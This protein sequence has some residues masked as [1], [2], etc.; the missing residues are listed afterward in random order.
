MGGRQ[1]EMAGKPEDKKI[2]QIQLKKKKNS[3][4]LRDTDLVPM[5]D[6]LRLTYSY[7]VSS[8]YV[9]PK[10]LYFKRPFITN[11]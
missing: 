1:R 6:T 8:Y 3:M 5:G 10:Y 9:N 7:G 11:N 4:T 2:R